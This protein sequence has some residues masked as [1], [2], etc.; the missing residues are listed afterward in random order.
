MA[1]KGQDYLGAVKFKSAMF[2]SNRER[3][4][5][6]LMLLTFG[7]EK[8]GLSVFREMVL[9]NE[10]SHVRVHVAEFDK[11]HEYK[12]SKYLPVVLKVMPKL[13]EVAFKNLGCPVLASPFCENKH[14]SARMADVFKQML[15]VAPHC[16]PIQSSISRQ[17]VR[18]QWNEAH[19]L[20]PKLPPYRPILLSADGI[21]S[22]PKK[23]SAG[24]VDSDAAA[25]VEYH[26]AKVD[27]ILAWSNFDNLREKDENDA[28]KDRNNPPSAEELEMNDRLLLP[29][30][31]PPKVPNARPLKK[32]WLWKICGDDH[33][34]EELKRENKPVLIIPDKV[35]KVVIETFN[36]KK[37]I[38]LRYGAAYKDGGHL[39]RSETYH[40]FQI[41][42]LANQ[43]S[44]SHYVVFNANGKRYGPHHP[45]HREPYPR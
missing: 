7:S 20:Y 43:K 23:P 33:E 38:E 41:G 8:Q 39:Y 9:S 13:Q 28:P 22:D 37:I 34:D 15:K 40:G 18:G 4:P 10:F 31:T 35:S 17:W 12:I 45:A 1:L 29:K 19:G 24:L 3:R 21:G 2:Q 26:D 30:G 42:D 27:I 16:A 11:T 44:G 6:G 14:S 32:P 36:G 5:A 25:W